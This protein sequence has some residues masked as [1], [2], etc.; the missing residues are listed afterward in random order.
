M[1]GRHSRT[2]SSSGPRG[3]TR[4]YRIGY[5]GAEAPN[6]FD[7]RSEFVYQYP[8]AA[9]EIG[10]VAGTEGGDTSPV[11]VSAPFDTIMPRPPTLDSFTMSGRAACT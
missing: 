7:L 4:R 8:G 3:E 6:E 10:V 11:A 5:L 2:Q 1:R 9:K